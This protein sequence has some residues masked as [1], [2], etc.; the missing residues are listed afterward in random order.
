MRMNPETSLA[1]HAITIRQYI[2]INSGTEEL[3]TDRGGWCGAVEN[4]PLA[5]GPSI[6]LH[7]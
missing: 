7:W 4:T 6:E 3:F 1:N 5:A 2:L